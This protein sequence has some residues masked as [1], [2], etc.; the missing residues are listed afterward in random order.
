M[1]KDGVLI[2]DDNR[3]NQP[4][5]AGLHCA[6]EDWGAEAARFEVRED[7]ARSGG[8]TG[9]PGGKSTRDANI[10]ESRWLRNVVI[11]LFLLLPQLTS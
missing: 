4:R 10:F 8:R 11:L 5:G 6:R 7:M 3:V 1:L 9:G 2:V